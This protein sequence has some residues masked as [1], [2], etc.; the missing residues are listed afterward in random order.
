MVDGGECKNRRNC[1]VAQKPLRASFSRPFLDRQDFIAVHI[2]SKL[3]RVGSWQTKVAKMFLNSPVIKITAHL[4]AHSHCVIILRSCLLTLGLFLR[5]LDRKLLVV[6]S[7][8]SDAEWVSKAVDNVHIYGLDD[9]ITQWF[10]LRL[11]IRKYFFIR[12]DSCVCLL[13]GCST[14]SERLCNF[15]F[16]YAMMFIT[17]IAVNWTRAI[18]CLW[19]FCA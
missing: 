1:H 8:R 13:V 14:W 15:A 4:F 6:A 2:L 9:P 5:F 16:G 12:N 10:L 18:I 3:I 11:L 7:W 17:W 19:E